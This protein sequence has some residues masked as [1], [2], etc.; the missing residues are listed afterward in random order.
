MTKKFEDNKFTFVLINLIAISIAMLGLIANSIFN[1]NAGYA[2]GAAASTILFVVLCLVY[3]QS[4]QEVKTRTR[5]MFFMSLFIVAVYCIITLLVDISQLAPRT[6]AGLTSMGIAVLVFVGLFW[7][8]GL[9][10]ITRLVLDMFNIR[11]KVYESLLEGKNPFRRARADYSETAVEQ[12]AAD[13]ASDSG[14]EAQK[15]SAKPKSKAVVGTP[16]KEN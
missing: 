4:S 2:V 1:R 6:F 12:Q 8:I 13:P 5:D 7:V 11:I 10:E 15:K 9:W 14:A 16:P 3:T